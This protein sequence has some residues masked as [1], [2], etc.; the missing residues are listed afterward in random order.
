MNTIKGVKYT[1]V[2]TVLHWW[3]RVIPRVDGCNVTEENFVLRLQLENLLDLVLVILL[4]GGSSESHQP[5]E[6]SSFL[7]SGID[8]VLLYDSSILS[9]NSFLLR[10][11]LCSRRGS[12]P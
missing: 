5:L 10:S 2:V 11:C 7:R 6:E 12:I 8:N 9:M 1:S 4:V 3:D